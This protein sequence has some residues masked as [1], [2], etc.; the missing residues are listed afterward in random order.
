M[1]KSFLF[2]SILIMLFS[3]CLL[4]GAIGK[5]YSDNQYSVRWEIQPYKSGNYFCALTIKDIYTNETYASPKIVC[6]KG[7]PAEIQLT[8]DTSVNASVMVSESGTA[9]VYSVN[10]MKNNIRVFAQDA[11]IQLGQ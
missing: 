9:V 5:N 11:A 3:V 7:K 4:S 6:L 1:K 10:I 8:G 2:S